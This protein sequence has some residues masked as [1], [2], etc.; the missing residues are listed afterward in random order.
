[1]KSK[2]TIAATVFGFLY[3][4]ESYGLVGGAIV[5]PPWSDPE[6]NPCATLP[7]GWQ[8]LYWP[9]L[10]KCFKIFQ[11]G[12]PCP[13]TMELSPVGNSRKAYKTGVSAECRCP[14]GTALSAVTN[15]CHRLFE[16]GPCNYGE[17]F[18]PLSEDHG[19][20]KLVD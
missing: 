6:K 7:G 8:L 5:P 15:Q 14:P 3:F 13:E 4:F 10:D 1:M 19:T 16:R 11:V 20:K 18:S 12:H 9:P 17:Y 2:S